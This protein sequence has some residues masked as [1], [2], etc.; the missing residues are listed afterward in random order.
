MKIRSFQNPKW[1]TM[2]KS[3]VIILVAFFIVPH[4]AS[5]THIVGGQL[6]YTCQGKG[7]YE[8]VLTMRR[9]CNQG[10]DDAQ[11]DDPASIGFYDATTFKFITELFIPFNQDDTLNEFIVSDCEVIGGSVCVHETTYKK[12]IG[13]P[14]RETGYIISYQRCCRNGS[15]LNIVDP[16]ET[17]ATWTAEIPATAQL[18][19]ND[20]PVFND[21][22]DIYLCQGDR[23]EFDHSA[24]DSDGDSLAY[25]LC[26][27]YSGAT[28][29]A[30]MPQPPP[31]PPYDTVVW[32]PG[33]S[34]AD[35]LGNP[36]DPLSID[37]ETGMLT[38]TPLSLGQYVI[39]I[40]VEEWR[41]GELISTYRRD[42]QYNIEFCR[43]KSVADFTFDIPVCND[44]TVNFINLTDTANTYEW[45]F[46]FE[47]DLT[48]TSDEENPSYT[49]P[50]FGTYTVMLAASTDTFCFDTIFKQVTLV[51]ADLDPGFTFEIEGCQEEIVINT[52]NT[53]T[54]DYTSL[55][56]ELIIGNDTLTG[57][58]NEET[59]VIDQEGTIT[60][61]ITITDDNGCQESFSQTFEAQF[62]IVPFV[63]QP[64]TICLNDCTNLLVN[65]DPDLDYTWDPFVEPNLNP[66]VCP[67][68]NTTYYVTVSDGL[69]TVVDSVTVQV[70]G[71]DSFEIMVDRDTC[72]F[73][74]TLWVE[75]GDG[76]TVMWAN[77]ENFDPVISTENMINVEVEGT[78]TFCV[79]VT[80][81]T[82][83]CDY[84]KCVTVDSDHVIQIETDFV[85]ESHIDC[86]GA[87]ISLNPNFNPAYKY[88]WSPVS[89]FTDPNEAN[90]IVSINESQWVYVTVFS[91]ENMSCFEVDSIYI[92][93]ISLFEVSADDV[94]VYCNENDV[95][96]IANV[97]D[98]NANITWCDANGMQVGAGSVL[99]YEADSSAV[100]TIKAEV[101]GCEVTSTATV[102]YIDELFPFIELDVE[103]DTVFTGESTQ[104][105]VVNGQTGWNYQWSPPDGLDN[106]NIKNPIATPD[107]TTVYTVTVTDAEGCT[108]SGDVT[109]AVIFTPCEH[110]YI[111]IP[112]AFTPN[113]DG[114]NDQFRVMG[115]VIDE[116][117]MKIYNRWGELVFETNDPNSGWDGKHRG[118]DLGMDVFAYVINIICLNVVMNM[119]K[120][121]MSH[122]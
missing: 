108:S 10:A 3:F 120:K 35:P 88:E 61:T 75:V 62:I 15:I 18:L 79:K 14:Y 17:G 90:P 24:T 53:S 74:Q 48:A 65:P 43:D 26:T 85:P 6:T 23:L 110:P 5:A 27:P 116:L 107:E 54:G 55:E 52:T 2:T 91:M 100:F 84:I 119:T 68:E 73:A 39:G 64:I 96:L 63:S 67:T 118:E 13:L 97:T 47:N 50:D 8:I 29:D 106:P 41:N 92:E 20:S 49:Y 4:W 33:Y 9:D 111:F 105:D 37:P 112:N 11:F 117:Q 21:W 57:N 76:A 40:C 99:S 82:G 25:K 93:A 12:T 46:D 115:N 66:L 34:S 113:S 98:P 114:V 83:T 70:L 1:S 36:A 59:F 22:P 69:C 122:S 94:T 28:I 71:D 87:E 101:L 38:G 45:L 44:R 31:K 7:E 104:L 16:I 42:F 95:E 89:L 19:C 77:D 109:A 56:W 80:D 72:S 60:I 32:A 58:M 78:K 81:P 86:F 121:V 51:E 103:P 102:T 30:P